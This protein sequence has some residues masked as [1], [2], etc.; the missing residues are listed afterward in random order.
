MP[1]L[2][3]QGLGTSAPSLIEDEDETTKRIRRIEE[4]SQGTLPSR[5][6]LS[7]A[8]SG[9]GEAQ[10]TRAA[11]LL[12]RYFD[13][14]WST[15]DLRAWPGTPPSAPVSVLQDPV[16]GGPISLETARRILRPYEVS[17]AERILSEIAARSPQE[18][19]RG[20]VTALVS[21]E[22]AKRVANAVRAL[23]PVRGTDVPFAEA[24]A[25]AVAV[26]TDRG[27][28]LDLLER[29]LEVVSNLAGLARHPLV[30]MEIA[31][32]AT[33]QG[34]VLR[35]PY[36]VARI[37]A[38][39]AEQAITLAETA[40][41]ARPI[42]GRLIAGNI[43]MGPEAAAALETSAALARVP[44]QRLDESTA[45]LTERAQVELGQRLVMGL[46]LPGDFL[47]RFEDATK[48]YVAAGKEIAERTRI[49]FTDSWVGRG[50]MWTI[51]RLGRPFDAVSRLVLDVNVVFA[52][53]AYNENPD[54][55]NV[56]E[57]LADA[58]DIIMG[59][60][61]AARELERD[62]GTPPWLTFVSQIILGNKIDPLVRVANL[63]KTVR[64]GKLLTE[65]GAEDW[66][67]AA[68]RW[69]DEP[70]ARFGPLKDLTPPQ[71]LVR[72]ALREKE[73]AKYFARVVSNY[74]AR[75]FGAGIDPLVAERIWTFSRNARK[76][77]LSESE[78]VA[79]VRRILIAGLGVA[80]PP[81]SAAARLLGE[82]ESYVARRMEQL[83]LFL[84]D[85][86]RYEAPVTRIT[87]PAAQALRA[88]E[89]AMTDFRFG[90]RM[91]EIPHR[92]GPILRAEHA[93]RTTPLAD[94][95]VGRITRS[96][97]LG[98][99][100]TP[101][102]IGAYMQIQV[103]NP[104]A[105]VKE[106]RGA[107]L[108]AQ[109]FSA[110]EVE[111]A[112]LRF[113]GIIRQTSGSR[114]QSAAAFVSKMER[115]MLRRTWRRYG[116]D[117][118][119]ADQILKRVRQRYPGQ[120]AEEVF[121]VLAGEGGPTLVRAPILATQEINALQMI[122]PALVRRGI[123]EV[124]GT[125]R[126]YNQALMRGLGADVKARAARVPLRR[127]ID[128]TVDLL[129]QDAFLS[130]YRPLVVIRPAYVLRIVYGE[131]TARF[132]A[133]AGLARRLQAGKL[134]SGER[135]IAALERAGLREFAER[136]RAGRRTIIEAP[137][138]AEVG[139]P[140]YVVV[141]HPAEIGP[142]P[143]VAAALGSIGRS[144]PGP[145]GSR[146]EQ[147]LTSGSW[148][149]V[150]RGRE[151]FY[152]WWFHALVHQFGRD[153]VGY[154]YLDDIARGVPED[155][156][157]AEAMA[158]LTSQEGRRYASRI[159]GPGYT[160]EA[161]EQQVRL[162]VR[163]AR[164]LTGGNA[165]LARAAKEGTLTPEM[166]RAVPEQMIPEYVH[167]PEIAETV[168]A[169]VGPAKRA[170]N[171]M[172]RWILQEPTNRLNRN[173]YFASWY[174]RM[175]EA[176]VRAAK[177]QGIKLT[178]EMVEGMRSAARRFAIDQVRRI[179]FDAT[180]TGR[181]DEVTRNF[182]M[183]V[184]P[185]LEAFVSWGRVIRQNPSVIPW[186]AR[187]GLMASRSGLVQRDEQTGQYVVPMS[188]W[189]GAAPLLAAVTGGRLRPVGQGGGWELAAPLASFNLFMQGAVPVPT[190]QIAGELPIP[191]PS[192]NP[193]V[194][195]LLQ[196]LVENSEIDA[197]AKA[198]L[199]SWLF[200]YGSV[201]P[202]KPGTLLPA[203][204]H[205]SLAATFPEW[206]EAEQNM[207]A[208]HFLQLQQAM[209]LDP[210]PELA[211]KQA[212]MFAGLRA[213]FAL[214]FPA[215]PRIEFPTK[216]LEEEWRALRETSPDWTTAR[217]RFLEAHPGMDLI[218]VSRTMWSEENPSPVQI[219]ATQA[220]SEL[221]NTK[222]ARGFA[223]KH[224]AW[225]WAIIPRELRTGELDIGGFFAQLASGQRKAYSPTEF[226][227]N[228][229]VQR[230]WDA[231]AVVR[232]AWIAWQEAHPDLG[233][234]DPPY[235]ERRMEYEQ[236]IRHIEELNPAWRVARTDLEI[237]G[238]EPAVLAEARRL[239]ADPTFRKTEAGRWL[240]EYLE[241]R[242]RTIEEMR[243]NNVSSIA[244]V[245]AERLGITQRYER[246]VEALNERYPDGAT[247]YRLFFQE[248]LRK[249]PN[250]GERAIDRLPEAFVRDELTPW[251]E[252]FERL[253]AAPDQAE[254]EL[255]RSRA[256]DALR[257]FANASFEQYPRN[258]NPLVLRWNAADLPWR[259]EYLTGIMARPYAFLNRFDKEIILGDR[260][261]PAAELLWTQYLQMRSF[262][263]QR[264]ATDPGF[265]SS[266]AYEALGRWV[267][268]QASRNRVFARQVQAANTWGY[269]LERIV[270]QLFPEQE[271]SGPYWEA[272]FEATR[273]IQEMVDKAKL[274]GSW[275]ARAKVAYNALRALLTDYIEE[276][277][278]TSREFNAQWRYLEDASGPDPL[279][280][281]L[282]PSFGDYYGPIQGYPG[283]PL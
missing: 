68:L 191:V 27:L 173:P 253:R 4:V 234:G 136:L 77:G 168:L 238:L 207:Q 104:Q 80:P 97:V 123:S 228:A 221:L 134:T 10:L 243:A 271:N 116:I 102:R 112:A 177:A 43:A 163:Y 217:Q 32:Q 74:R 58:W 200:E 111:E 208:T 46:E 269:T 36:D 118:D 150:E 183:F 197:H 79:E 81:G 194:T 263:A 9:L 24:L 7:L 22:D 270:P 60:T 246:A 273:T 41:A 71:H 258:R 195:A 255:A 29:N 131:E 154:R 98:P 89:D 40:P 256:Y 95:L 223:E 50:L 128:Y 125:W 240:V 215:A 103:E 193:Q 280:S 87:K 39:E 115:E 38:P 233:P 88:I 264:E 99:E 2:T 250:P 171:A 225:V 210:D 169:R 259:E 257:E 214:V 218:T 155:R 209:G 170:V 69:V 227:A 30:Q 196:N 54:R 244:T 129:V 156:S 62:V 35:G 204:L 190:G 124:I 139:L 166:L 53:G 20:R 106:F 157:V 279:V 176:Q 107:L 51:E 12:A 260:T 276:L 110:E 64:A 78:I 57:A 105:A 249:V 65:I 186:V 242:R 13:V 267:A 247:A 5:M 23:A 21:R 220:V 254:D 119:L 56:V 224:P 93:L 268:E 151:D 86:S 113:A 143:A 59:R 130:W 145:I 17:V 1:I 137:E 146:M 232:D 192:L 199:S 42:E 226:I 205:H 174:T 85:G 49:E 219:P 45:L 92:A 162:G 272:L 230:G 165:E 18:A 262:I 231:Y 108:R 66:A 239:A 182:L 52:P 26:A 175:F 6:T 152:E 237:G 132:L 229:E 160:D 44:T 117:P 142:E 216:E 109:V 25:F 212:R 90:P 266:A 148:G 181:L 127:F 222:G 19:V 14:P 159:M 33:A 203:W 94:S 140:G 70:I 213:F 15:I 283:G 261:S 201:D 179:M 76:A 282:M 48:D 178:P 144:I 101:R 47:K 141:P 235:E 120:R 121:A 167:G 236:D 84:A 187:T 8:Q 135:V 198:R 158:W 72:E 11:R 114:G 274:G 251:W 133:T 138:L 61:T 34:K 122:D 75:Y 96:L 265:S 188:W 245:T 185:Y 252:R 147:A 126:R 83:P 55:M 180:R 281:Y 16:T 28:D 91:M 153:E 189:A 211:V 63:Y 73:P 241:L 67:A 82:T 164:Q 149:V 100:S 184:Q 275:D 248:D 161:L 278:K 277:R 206:F 37:I 172:S 3:P 31:R 202:S